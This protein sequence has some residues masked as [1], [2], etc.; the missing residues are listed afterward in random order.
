VIAALDGD[1]VQGDF[2]DDGDGLRFVG[3]IHLRDVCGAAQH[4]RW[5]DRCSQPDIEAA[6]LSGED[7]LGNGVTEV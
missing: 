3:Q 7:L 2:V 5:D 1:D 6:C 4:L